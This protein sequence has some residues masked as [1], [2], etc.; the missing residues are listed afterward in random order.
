MW[1][2]FT[3][4]GNIKYLDFLPKILKQYNNTRQFNKNDTNKTFK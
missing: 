3:I 2:Q 1:K 4:K